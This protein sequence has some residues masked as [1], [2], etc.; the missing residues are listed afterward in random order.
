MS[1]HPPPFVV[2]FAG[3]A[4]HLWTSS[5]SSIFDVATHVKITPPVA[6]EIII[7]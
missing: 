4:S 3:D 2:G 6:D 5:P 7:L 1:L